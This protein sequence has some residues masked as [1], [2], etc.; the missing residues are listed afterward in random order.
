LKLEKTSFGSIVIDGKKYTKDIYLNVDGS[1]TKRQKKLSKPYS[2]GHTVLGPDEIEL[3]LE[4]KP[5]TIIIGK[6]QYGILPIP[7]ESRA[8]LEKSGVIVIEDKTPIVLPMINELINE[9]AKI[10]A[11]LHL[12]C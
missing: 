4:Q 6:G 12:T 9:N 8:L 5:Q 7:K 10:V 2:K 3:L 1:I 11:I